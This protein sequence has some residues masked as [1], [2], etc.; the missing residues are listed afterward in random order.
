MT[1]LGRKIKP[2]LYPNTLLFSNLPAQRRHTLA[3]LT[4]CLLLIVLSACSTSAKTTTPAPSDPASSAEP[5]TQAISDSTGNWSVF[6]DTKF[7]FDKLASDKDQELAQ[8]AVA[9]SNQYFEEHGYSAGPATIT[10]TFDEGKEFSTGKPDPQGALIIAGSDWESFSDFDTYKIFAH[11]YY[12][13]LQMHLSGSKSTAESMAVWL[14]EG[15]AE[16]MAR[17]LAEANGF[18][19]FQ[20]FKRGAILSAKSSP[21]Q[22]SDLEDQMSYE[23]FDQLYGGQSAIA[24]DY[25]FNQFGEDALFSYWENLGKSRD[26]KSAFQTTFGLTPDAFYQNY[27]AYLKSL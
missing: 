26:W 14:K 21:V 23:H 27:E 12:H 3:S 25:L 19:N 5:T 7:V 20:E 10:F 6:K 24:I 18:S 9:D 22:L 17:W 11:E 15:C 13:V 4:V 2:A 1:H 16:Y 8:R